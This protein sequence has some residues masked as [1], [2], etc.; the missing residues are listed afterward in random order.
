MFLEMLGNPFESKIMTT[1]KDQ[2]RLFC[3]RKNKLLEQQSICSGAIELFG[4]SAGLA[5]L[6]YLDESC[7]FEGEDMVADPGRGLLH[8][9][10]ELRQRGG[11]SHEQ[12]QD[13]P[14]AR[15]GEKFDTSK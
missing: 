5:D 2:G 14:A 8:R 12:P 7:R 6:A 11:R 9:P 3:F 15:I 13:I 4:H 10:R 1:G